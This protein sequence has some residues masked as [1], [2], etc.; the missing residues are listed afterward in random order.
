[1]GQ[2]AEDLEDWEARQQNGGTWDK[3]AKQAFVIDTGVEDRMRG[4]GRI[5]GAQ[6]IMDAAQDAAGDNATPEEIAISAVP[7]IVSKFWD[8]K[9]PETVRRHLLSLW[10]II[11]PMATTAPDSF[12]RVLSEFTERATEFR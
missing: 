1:M 5:D 10:P 9:K 12:D 3:P 4:Y 7:L 11:A 8:A 6:I 2:A